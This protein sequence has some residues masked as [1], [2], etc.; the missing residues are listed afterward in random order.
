MSIEFSDI[1]IE[2]GMV[3]VNVKISLEK[4]FLD[5]SGIYTLSDVVVKEEVIKSLGEEIINYMEVSTKY[6]IN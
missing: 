4:G 6:P 3:E 1:V 5:G 2:N